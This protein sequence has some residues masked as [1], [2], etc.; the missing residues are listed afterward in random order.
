MKLFYFKHPVGNF[1]DDLNDWL[2]DELLPGWREWS[3]E[4]ILFGVGTLLN[5]ENLNPYRSARLLVLGSGVGYGTV[6]VLPLEEYWDF[7]S[8]RGPESSKILGLPDNR[9]LID[10]T[11]M[12]PELD[13]FQNLPKSEKPIFIPHI[14]SVD[15]QD[16]QATCQKIGIDFIPPSG[17]AKA[18]IRKIAGSPL[19]LAES[20]HAAIIADAFRVPWVAVSVSHQFNTDKWYDWTQ[21]LDMKLHVRPLFPE[22][23]YLGKIA[24]SLHLGRGEAQRIRIMPQEKIKTTRPVKGDVRSFDLRQRVRHQMEKLLLKRA[25]KRALYAPAMLS[26]AK[27]LADKKARYRA[28]LDAVKQDYSKA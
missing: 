21:S 16:W 10:P 18:I 27:I 4:V 2:W 9:G 12:L 26:D 22:L 19:V 11:I 24:R 20:M 25:L 23:A 3:P 28:C 7:R 14:G 5:E 1:G 15:R 17:D 6:P 8:V 13:E